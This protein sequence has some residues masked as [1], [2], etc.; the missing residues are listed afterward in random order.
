MHRGEKILKEMT[1][2]RWAYLGFY[3]FGAILIVF[4]GIGLLIIIITE[5]VRRGN[6]YYVTDKRVMHDFTFLSRKVSSAMY[7]KIQDIHFT[8]G[9]IERIVGIGTIHINTAGTTFIEIKFK[10]VENPVSVKRIIEDKMLK[11]HKR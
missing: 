2:S 5:L 8:Q 11:H 3:L 1:P 6:K 7:E 10:G 9:I 4:M